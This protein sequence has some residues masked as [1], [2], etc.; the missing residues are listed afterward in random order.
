MT[1]YSSHYRQAIDCAVLVFG[2]D[3]GIAGAWGIPIVVTFNASVRAGDVLL[4]LV[5]LVIW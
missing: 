1:Y 5:M 3:G 4:L 2:I